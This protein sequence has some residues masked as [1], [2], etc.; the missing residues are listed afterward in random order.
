MV[1]GL[2]RISDVIRKHKISFSEAT[3]L[4]DLVFEKFGQPLATVDEDA[5]HNE[6]NIPGTGILDDDN[7]DGDIN[8][9]DEY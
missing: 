9:K 3:R 4:S 8:G 7:V 5:A 1:G 2:T 6:I